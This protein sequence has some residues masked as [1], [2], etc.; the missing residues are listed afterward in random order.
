[1]SVF[2][3]GGSGFVGTNL[4]RMLLAG[5]EDV[6][7]LVRPT[8]DLRRLTDVLPHVRVHVGSLGSAEFLAGVMRAIAPTTVFHLAAAAGHA[9]THRA[10]S[11]ALRAD[12]MGTLNL[13]HAMDGRAGRLVYLGS[14][15]EYSASGGPLTEGS[16]LGPASFRGVAKAASTMLVRQFGSAHGLPTTVLR[17]FHVYGPWESPSRVVPVFVRALRDGRQISVPPA[18]YGRDFVFATDLADACVRAADVAQAAAPVFNIGS[19]I[20][21]S[22]ADLVTKLAAVMRASPRWSAEPYAVAGWDGGAAYADITRAAEGL[23]WQP[24]HTLA[25]GLRA[26]VEWWDR[27]GGKWLDA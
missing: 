22:I 17:P 8:S 12:V 21:T 1:M 23:G 18:G 14:S 9:R 16:S 2:V 26:T 19:G 15:L 27:S 25:E 20:L 5:N 4:V 24:S 11:A 3:T 7:I 6:H 10:R 13:L